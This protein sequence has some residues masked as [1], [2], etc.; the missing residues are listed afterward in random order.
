MKVVVR[1][2]D[3]AKRLTVACQKFDFSIDAVT[4]SRECDAKSLLGIMSLDLTGSINLIL[5]CDE[6]KKAECISEITSDMK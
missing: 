1:N 2:L 4:G 5:N 6:D 3:D